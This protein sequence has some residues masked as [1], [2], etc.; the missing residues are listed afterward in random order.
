M[1]RDSEISRSLY[2]CCLLFSLALVAFLFGAS[3]E[4]IFPLFMF[5]LLIALAEWVYRGD[6]E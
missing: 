2:G 4:W 5:A 1:D 3:V 6:A